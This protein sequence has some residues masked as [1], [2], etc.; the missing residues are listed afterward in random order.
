MWIVGG[1]GWAYDIGY[2]GLDH[3]VAQPE[4]VNL[5]VL[6]T[7]VYSNTGGQK[8]KASPLGA[9]TKFASAGKRTAK[10]DLGLQAMSYQSV[11]VAAL[12]YS[13]NAGQAVKAL[14]EGES[15]P[16][17][18]LFICYCP[19]IEHGIDMGNTQA[20]AKAAVDSG[21]WPLYRYD[22]RRIDQ[23]LNPLQLDS[24]EPKITF[25]DYAMGQNRFRRLE[26]EHPG[27]FPKVMEDAEIAVK[28]HWLLYKQLAGLD[29]TEFARKV[30]D[31]TKHAANSDYRS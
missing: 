8:S 14:V 4:D 23:G 24:R 1:D 15:Y 25:R 27:E 3:V 28:R 12:A 29:Y 6:D 17:P 22:P 21:Y 11:Y 26:R 9:I 19:C 30:D 18:A 7:E 16:G 13:A 20:Q 5:M 31:L 10:K 2:G